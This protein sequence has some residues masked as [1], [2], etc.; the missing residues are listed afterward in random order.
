M[1]IE[2]AF[3]R[4]GVKLGK[5]FSSI[6]H[7]LGV[8]NYLKTTGE[9][10]IGCRM[11]TDTGYTVRFNFNKGS[12]III[13]K[14]YINAD[15]IDLWNL[16]DLN[17]FEKPSYT[18]EL[19]K[20]ANVLSVWSYIVKSFLH[21]N[22]LRLNESKVPV[23]NGIKQYYDNVT[24]N[25]RR[26]FADE[27]GIDK[28]YI[29][30]NKDAWLEVLRSNDL[31]DTW[32]DF[33]DSLKAIRK[34][35]KGKTENNSYKIEY[36]KFQDEVQACDS[37]EEVFKRLNVGIDLLLR[38]PMQR[39]LI[40]VGDPGSG[41]TKTVTKFLEDTLG[42][43]GNKW[44]YAVL[45]RIS[46]SQLYEILYKNRNKIIVFDEASA[47]L[48]HGKNK[49]VQDMLKS[50]LQFSKLTKDEEKEFYGGIQ[51]RKETK[52]V[53]PF[54]K[55]VKDDPVHSN[56]IYYR[57]RNTHK[58]INPNDENEVI[59][60][61]RK[62]DTF[63]SKGGIV[64]YE[65][66]KNGETVAMALPER[67]YFNG[68]II[69]ISNDSLED[70]NPAIIDRS[71]KVS[72]NLSNAGMI[73]RIRIIASDMF[74]SKDIETVINELSK[75]NKRISLRTFFSAMNAY[76]TNPDSDYWKIASSL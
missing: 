10:G 33:L 55:L 39:S 65:S 2:S 66:F 76:A 17:N 41:K 50:T 47:F 15:S 38:S 62:L 1:D 51:S 26:T 9:K 73:D 36:E 71:Y 13:N 5:P 14:D 6:M 70:I 23:I 58:F 21:N 19:N 49:A 31:E 22:V 61:C 7:V 53:L 56:I 74:D 30:G 42:S 68:K 24:L 43:I 35:S 48:T 18:I 45:S 67:F 20:N 60:Y 64:G 25:K 28:A 59:E 72:I 29:T 52:T 27:H 3:K 37:S 69:F 16:K 4:L 63:I 75:R 32:D 54:K 44:E 34:A 46:D 11:F 12:K 40:V 8:E 57:T